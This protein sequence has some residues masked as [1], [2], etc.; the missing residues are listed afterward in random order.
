VIPKV[1]KGLVLARGLRRR[2]PRCGEGPLFRKWIH[3]HPRCPACNVTLLRN[4]GDIWIWIILTD[5]IPIA[6]GVIAVYFGWQSTNWI[7]AAVFFVALFT[8][9]IATLRERQGL[10]IALDYLW[11]IYAKDP[12]DEIH[13]GRGAVINVR[14]A[15]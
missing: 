14:E 10:A 1:P 6:A 8:P 3:A 13:D 5:R 2:C 7:G 15:R 12:A 9:L 11:R 4:Q